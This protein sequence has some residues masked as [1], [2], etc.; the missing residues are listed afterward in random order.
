MSFASKDA[1]PNNSDYIVKVMTETFCG[2]QLNRIDRCQ[3]A[4]TPDP[5][6]CKIPVNSLKRCEFHLARGIAKVCSGQF[7]DLT[8]CMQSKSPSACQAQ[9]DTMYK[10]FMKNIKTG[11]SAKY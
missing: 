3:N 1:S 8:K 5:F 7:A 4:V 6:D 2:S 10:C 9:Y 11:R